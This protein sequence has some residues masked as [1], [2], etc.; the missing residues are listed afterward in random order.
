MASFYRKFIEDYA[1]VAK[2]LTSMTRG[3]YANIKSSQSSKLASMLDETA[4][5]SFNDLKSIL[6]SSEILAFPCFTKPFHLTTNPSNYVIGA[7]L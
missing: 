4:L 2:P 3:L 1:K 7:V 6:S 5:Q